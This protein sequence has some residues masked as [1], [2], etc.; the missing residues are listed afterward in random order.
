MAFVLKHYSN[1]LQV[2]TQYKKGIAVKWSV[3]QPHIV[4]SSAVGKEN[5]KYEYYF[6]L[7]INF[8]FLVNI[9]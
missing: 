8:F 6:V 5:K 7:F 4:D 9:F 3:I 2:H 1:N